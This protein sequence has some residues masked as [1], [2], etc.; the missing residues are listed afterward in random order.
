MASGKLKVSGFSL[1]WLEHLGLGFRGNRWVGQTLTFI[2]GQREVV[3]LGQSLVYGPHIE[4][5][6][7]GKASA[8]WK[9]YA[10]SC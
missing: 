7:L 3:P 8:P 2:K 10:D 9:G 5:S 4:D 6:A 1:H